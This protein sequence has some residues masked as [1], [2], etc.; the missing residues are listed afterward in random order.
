M[1]T[2]KSEKPFAQLGQGL[3]ALLGATESNDDPQ[4]LSFDVVQLPSQQP[5]RYFDPDKLKQLQLSIE[6]HGVLEPLLVR[7][8][9]NGHYELVAGERR[10][11]A[12]QAA[13]LSEIPVVIRELSDTEALQ[14]ALIE[15]LQR[16]DL[17]PVEETLAVLQLLASLLKVSSDEV[18][19]LLYQMRNEVDKNG[20]EARHNVM[21]NSESQIIEETFTSLGLMGW[22]SFVQNRLP[23]LKLPDNILE[24]LERG[25]LEYTKAK[26]IARLKDEEQQEA[27]LAEAISENL[28]L[29]QIRERIRALTQPS[30]S[31][32]T[33]LKTRFNETYRRVNSSKIWENPE[34][35]KKLESLLDEIEGLLQ[36]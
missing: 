2:K 29:S 10:Y 25:Q 7:P 8:K 19:S 11:R 28:S 15:N 14:I 36:S 26:A 31:G 4:T 6:Q 5:R 34:A 35:Q 13:G 23:L 20:K 21:P 18:K 17:N 33:D 12:A 16:E 30:S 24:A 9:G 32:K 1:A 3:D 22:R 27:L